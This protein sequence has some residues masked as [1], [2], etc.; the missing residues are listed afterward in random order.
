MHF[1]FIHRLEVVIVRFGEDRLVVFFRTDHVEVTIER[2]VT[3]VETIENV[4]AAARSRRHVE[5]L[6]GNAAGPKYQARF[7]AGVQIEDQ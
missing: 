7:L 1:A 4:D 3:L 2:P 5:R 6:E